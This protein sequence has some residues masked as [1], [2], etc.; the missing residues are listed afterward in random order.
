[1]V[2]VVCAA[3]ALARGP[4]ASA[5]AV[6]SDAV[7]VTNTSDV[8]NGNVSSIAALNAHPG[9]DGISLREAMEAADHTRGTGI[10]YIMFSH[11]LNGRTIALRSGGLPPIYRDHLVLE[12]VA[13]NGSSARVTIDGRRVRCN[14]SCKSGS[15]GLLAVTASEVTVRRLR[16]TGVNP[17]SWAAALLVGPGWQIAI[18]PVPSRKTIANVRKTMAN[19]RIEDNTFDE[20]GFTF[21]FAGPSANGLLVGPSPSL[22]HNGTLTHIS[23]VT[24]ARNTVLHYTGNADAVAVS[25]PPGATNSDVTIEDNTFDENEYSIEGGGTRII[26]N[27]ITTAISGALG[28]AINV[29]LKDTIL[30]GTLIE[31]NTIAVA[32]GPGINIDNASPS[33]GDAI[34]NTQ[35]VNDII[36]ASPRQTGI[37][38]AGGDYTAPSPSRVSGV[39]IENDTLVGEGTGLLNLIPN[40]RGAKG[41]QIT[42]VVIRNTIMWDPHGTPIPTGSGPVYLRAPDVVM[43]SLVSGPAWAGSN[44]NINANPDFVNEPA[45]DYHLAA[46]SPAINAGTTIGAPAY[47][48]D[49]ARRDSRPDIGAYEYAAAARPLLTVTLEPLGGNGTITSSPAGIKCETTCSAQFDPG[50][51]VTLAVKPDRRSRF[52][53]WG[54]ACSS[55]QPRCTITIN[56]GKTVTARF[57]PQ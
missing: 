19:V 9:R 42:G 15:Y 46:D 37:Y 12:G 48:I 13:P 55:R 41:N 30:N 39:T 10:V 36:R 22:S 26:G 11:A 6:S 56:G 4:E 35:I 44:G 38:I 8:V 3:G 5:A 31:G 24:I 18:H 28:I 2:V 17:V 53:G 52:L 25:R 43:N 7:V 45:G 21:P 32:N 51:R 47:D 57:G 49:G 27:T 16:F 14:F 54:G 34:L 20:R 29:G 23:G 40:G 1:V 50:T 33:G